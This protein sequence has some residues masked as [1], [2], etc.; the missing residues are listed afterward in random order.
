MPD[1]LVSLSAL[2]VL[3]FTYNQV[4]PNEGTKSASSYFESPSNCIDELRLSV[5]FHQ[6]TPSES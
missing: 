5:Q 2:S 3:G 6:L 4:T 1:T